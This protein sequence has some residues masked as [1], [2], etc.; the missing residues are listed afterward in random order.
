MAASSAL[1]ARTAKLRPVVEAV[2]VPAASVEL[3]IEAGHAGLPD[4][5]VGR[6]ALDAV[7][8]G[9]VVVGEVLRA[10]AEWRRRVGER[11]QCTKVRDEGGRREVMGVRG[12]AG[13]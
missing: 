11:R 7:V 3:R 13:L 1:A 9:E 10:R 4:L 12:R 8:E 2:L 6:A 5:L